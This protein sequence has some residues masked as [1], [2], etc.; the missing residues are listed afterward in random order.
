MQAIFAEGTIRLGALRSLARIVENDHNQIGFSPDLG[1]RVK[2]L[3]F[4]VRT[5]KITLDG[6][7][8]TLA[9]EPRQTSSQ[10]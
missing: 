9:G 7:S 3:T 4:W 5:G 8:Y 6:E 2:I 10:P 1:D